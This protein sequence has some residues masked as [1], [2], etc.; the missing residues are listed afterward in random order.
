MVSLRVVFPGA[1]S[2]HTAQRR[3]SIALACLRNEK[4]AA[5]DWVRISSAGKSVIAQAWPSLTINEDEI[6]L[7]R[8]HL[9]ALG[10]PVQVDLERI[11]GKDV[12]W[13]TAK[14]ITVSVHAPNVKEASSESKGKERETAWELAL[15]KE[16]LRKSTLE[17]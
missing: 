15:L 4:L 13:M 17:H 14:A 9:L 10:D 6:V 2:G 3:A 8:I 5:G 16:I 7:S 1:P 12:K 11:E